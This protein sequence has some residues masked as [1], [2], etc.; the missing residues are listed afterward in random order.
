[1]LA[2]DGCRQLPEQHFGDFTSIVGLFG[3]ELR[4]LRTVVPL[5][6]DDSLWGEALSFVIPT[7]PAEPHSCRK[8]GRNF[9]SRCR[10]DSPAPLCMLH[11]STRCAIPPLWLQAYVERTLEMFR[12]FRAVAG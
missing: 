7:L 4:R 1:M 10:R 11:V 12:Y 6:E 8:P 9:L 5:Q 3:R 2:Q